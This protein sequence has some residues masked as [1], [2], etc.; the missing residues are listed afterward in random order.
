MPLG[1]VLFR[2]QTGGHRWPETQ[3]GLIEHVDELP[4][5]KF[6]EFH[7]AHPLEAERGSIFQLDRAQ[8]ILYS[9][10]AQ[11]GGTAPLMIELP[12]TK[13]IAGNAARPGQ[14]FCRLAHL[15]RA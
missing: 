12:I 4:D 5:S 9:R 8:G 1:G 14:P 13:G 15:E 2:I 11:T 10:V 3:G 6:V 7:V